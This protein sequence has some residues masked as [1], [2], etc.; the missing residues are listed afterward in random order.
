MIFCNTPHFSHFAEKPGFAAFAKECG[1]SGNLQVLHLGAAIA[2]QIA[3]KGF[4]DQQLRDGSKTFGALLPD[5][6]MIVSSRKTPRSV[7]DLSPLNWSTQ[8]YGFALGSG[9]ID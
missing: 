9:L 7:S 8:N 1:D 3:M 2:V 6:R 4:A 5:R